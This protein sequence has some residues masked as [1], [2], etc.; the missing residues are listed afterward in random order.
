[1]KFVKV[2]SVVSE[3]K[4]VDGQTL[5]PHRAFVLYNLRE[6]CIIRVRETC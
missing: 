5:P 2:G 1:M 6:E 4:R 3:T